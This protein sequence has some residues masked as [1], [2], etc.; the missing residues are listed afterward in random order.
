M[1]FVTFNVNKRRN[2]MAVVFCSSWIIENLRE[3]N[4]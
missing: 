4:N 1:R 3:K 2:K